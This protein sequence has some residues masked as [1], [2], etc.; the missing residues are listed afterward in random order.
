MARAGPEAIPL[1][2]VGLVALAVSALA[3]GGSFLVEGEIGASFCL[4]AS[5]V[6]LIGAVLLFCYG[7]HVSHVA[8]ERAAQAAFEAQEAREAE[9]RQAT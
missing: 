7:L 9:E 8:A 1:N 5:Y 6:S 2:R 3:L 4:G